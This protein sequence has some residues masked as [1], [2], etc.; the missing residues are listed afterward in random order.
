MSTF[1]TLLDSISADSQKRGTQFE[2]VCKWFL[3]NDRRYTSIIE[4]VWL[5]EDWPDRWGRDCGIDLIAKG[6]DGKTWAVQAKCYDPEYHVTKKDVDSFLSE[7]TNELIDLRLLIASTDNIGKNAQGVIARQNVNHPV[8]EVL[9]QDLVTTDLIW[10]ADFEQ[11]MSG[12]LPKQIKYKPRPHQ[13]EAI[14]EVT[15]K[16]ESR[17]QLIMACG[18]GKTLTA[19][20]I[21]K[22]QTRRLRRWITMN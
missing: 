21:P 18:T 16:L 19:L 1:K 2:Y 3:E 22:I 14:Q 4:K 8:R 5:W 7:S 20:W 6:K 12:Y 17:G 13:V 15:S 9:R 11:L 10:P